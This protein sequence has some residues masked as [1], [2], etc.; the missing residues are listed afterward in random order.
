MIPIIALIGA[1]LAGAGVAVLGFIRP[2]R[3]GS[4]AEKENESSEEV[5]E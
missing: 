3:K 2:R 4:E 5:S 1:A